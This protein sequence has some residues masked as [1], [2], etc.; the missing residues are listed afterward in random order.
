LF[1]SGARLAESLPL[2][3]TNLEAE[4]PAASRPL[5]PGRVATT[6]AASRVTHAPSTSFVVTPVA[7]IGAQA[8]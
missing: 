1:P 4:R 6:V 3:P 5:R 2:P 8:P 7:T